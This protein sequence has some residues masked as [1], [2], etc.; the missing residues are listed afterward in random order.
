[1][2]GKGDPGL[3]QL[4]SNFEVH[5]NLLQRFLKMEMLGS[6]PQRLTHRPGARPKKQYFNS[7]KALGLTQVDDILR[8]ADPKSQP[9]GSEKKDPHFSY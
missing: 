6:R 3:G 1:M 7:P 4:F 8:N 5:K 9:F 2:G